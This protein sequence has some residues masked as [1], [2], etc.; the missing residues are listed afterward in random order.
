MYTQS[1]PAGGDYRLFADVAP[2]GAGS[3]V[4]SVPLK[5]TGAKPAWN[6]ALTPT[7]LTTTVDGI[8]ATLDIANKIL[9]IG[10]TIPVG[11][12]LTDSASKP[13][14]DLEPYLGAFGHLI[15]IHQDGQTF[16]HSHPMEDDAG[17]ALSKA[18]TVVFNARFPKPGRYKAWGQ[19]QRAG[20]VITV[21]FVFDVKGGAL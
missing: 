1:F 9:P 8:T 3:Q 4:L 15:L 6:T 14:T 21:P 10:R 7:P 2:K 19:F 18:G 5:V 13:I 17:L 12:K 11:F 16:V 20:K